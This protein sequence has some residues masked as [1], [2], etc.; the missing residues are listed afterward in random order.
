MRVENAVK[1]L[2]IY[3]ANAWSIFHAGFGCD[4]AESAMFSAI[5]LLGE[6]DG[7][8]A[9]FLVR[10]QTTMS[11]VDG[12]GTEAGATPLELIELA[13]HELRWPEFNPLIETRRSLFPLDIRHLDLLAA[14]DRDW[15]D[16]EYYR[17][18][19]SHREEGRCV[20]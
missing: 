2:D 1:L 15:T 13:I 11:T 3:I 17:R 18:Y 12:W 4:R 19:R 14:F 5:D 16:R 9:E 8:R 6:E 7:L 20:R 10:A